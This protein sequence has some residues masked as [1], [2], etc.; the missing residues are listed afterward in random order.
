MSAKAKRIITVL[1]LSAFVIVTPTVLSG[2]AISFKLG[3]VDLDGTISAADARLVLR[4][5][6]GLENIEQTPEEPKVPEQKSKTEILKDYIAA[7]GTENADGNKEIKSSDYILRPYVFSVSYDK[8]EGFS[9]RMVSK[10]DT[11]SEHSFSMI[12]PENNTD[13]TIVNYTSHYIFEYPY[14]QPG[15]EDIY[16][17]ESGTADIYIGQYYFG[18]ELEFD[19]VTNIDDLEIES[20]SPGIKITPSEPSNAGVSQYFSIAMSGW[21]NLLKEAGLTGGM[22]DIGFSNFYGMLYN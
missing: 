3:D 22:S 10:T 19:F 11:D 17:N 2:L 20:P 8:K 16:I 18:N 9:F 13:K 12:L 1:I 21:D 7:N 5:S 4:A 14:K 6:V 15:T